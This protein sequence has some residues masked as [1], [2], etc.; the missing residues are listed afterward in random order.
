MKKSIYLSILIAIISSI[1]VSFT[2]ANPFHEKKESN[3]PSQTL[4]TFSYQKENV[5]KDSTDEYDPSL[6]SGSELSD[7]NVFV[8]NYE[9][10]YDFLTMEAAGKLSSCV[11][12][13]LNAHGYGGYHE[14][15]I[16][17][18]TLIIEETYPRFVCSIDDSNK[19]LEIRY[20]SDLHQF[21]FDL[22]DYIY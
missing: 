20:R 11:A 21:E 13:Y 1:F 3:P 18:E 19:Y 5:Y 17:K 12:E 14:L 22:L 6:E 16:Q 7:N 10:L 2:L 9:I 4:G 15:T 8:T